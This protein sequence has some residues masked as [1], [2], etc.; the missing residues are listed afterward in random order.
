MKV[1][2]TNYDIVLMDMQ[3]PELD[4]LAATKMLR[5]LPGMEKLVI[6]ALTANAFDDDREMCLAAG[7]NDFIT[8]PFKPENMFEKLVWWFGNQQR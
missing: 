3:M 1:R 2:Q 7:M 4:G 8:K 5:T 6:I